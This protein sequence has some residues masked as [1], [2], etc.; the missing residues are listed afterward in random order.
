[1][2]RNATCTRDWRNYA[3]AD[4]H[5]ARRDGC[6][7]D[8][9]A[10]RW[11]KPSVDCEIDMTEILK[12]VIMGHTKKLTQDELDTI[13][14]AGIGGTLLKLQTTWDD[15]KEYMELDDEGRVPREILCVD[16]DA[17]EDDVKNAT[18]SHIR[19]A[20]DAWAAAEAEL[21]AQYTALN[22]KPDK[23]KDEKVLLAK[24][25]VNGVSK[26][27]KFKSCSQAERRRLYLPE[28]TK[29]SATNMAF[30]RIKKYIDRI[31]EKGDTRYSWLRDIIDAPVTRASIERKR[32]AGLL[33]KLE[34]GRMPY[35]LRGVMEEIIAS[36]DTYKK[37]VCEDDWHLHLNMILQPPVGVRR[38][39]VTTARVADGGIIFTLKKGNTCT[40]AVKCAMEY[41]KWMSHFEQLNSMSI[42]GR[43]AVTVESVT[44]Y[45]RSDRNPLKKLQKFIRSYESFYHGYQAPRFTLHDFRKLYVGYFLSF[46]E[47]DSDLTAAMRASVLLNH[48]PGSPAGAKYAIL[49]H[50]DSKSESD[51][52]VSSIMSDSVDDGTVTDTYD[53]DDGSVTE[54][55]DSDDDCQC[56]DTRG[57]ADM[58]QQRKRKI[59][60]LESSIIVLEAMMRLPAAQRA[61]VEANFDFALLP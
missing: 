59:E 55:Y 35:D 6:E 54:T 15:M 40:G 25:T 31:T 37:H 32:D 10:K 2:D 9:D 50:S 61:K 46:D 24:Y 27:T 51:S 8:R 11:Y 43:K 13:S 20:L 41:D 18:T 14:P 16:D 29:K 1:M 52:S 23:T 4:R 22:N 17:S 33:Y 42:T 28:P 19:C 7:F 34:K 56:E 12:Q 45:M 3:Y 38:T 60:E 58:V 47:G 21:H 39:E 44:E 57:L 48:N 26:T 30:T 36:F 53:S 5:K 49:K